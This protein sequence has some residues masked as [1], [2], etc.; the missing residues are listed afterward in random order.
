MNVIT[1]WSEI[2]EFTEEAEEAKFWE[3]NA[4]DVK[5]DIES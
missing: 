1:R 2:P 5:G 4:E 3:A